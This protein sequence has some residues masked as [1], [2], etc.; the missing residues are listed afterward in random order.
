MAVNVDVF[1]GADQVGGGR[2]SG[3]TQDVNN[4]LT[5]YV[6]KDAKYTFR[7]INSNGEIVNV[8]KEVGKDPVQVKLS[9]E[10]E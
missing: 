5:L 6:D 9:M 10:I 4:I 3:P 1:K 2:T 8:D 7:Y